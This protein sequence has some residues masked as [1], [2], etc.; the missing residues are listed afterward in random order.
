MS[1][2]EAGHAPGDPAPQVIWVPACEECGRQV[3]QDDD[4]E[5]RHY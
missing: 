4:E 1:A 2:D 5:W 3:A